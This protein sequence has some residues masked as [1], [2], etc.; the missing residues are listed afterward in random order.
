ME[1]GGNNHLETGGGDVSQ[2]EEEFGSK[3]RDSTDSVLIQTNSIH[4]IMSGM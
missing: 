2:E 3:R 1:Q 4:S